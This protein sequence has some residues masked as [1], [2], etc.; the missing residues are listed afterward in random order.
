[1]PDTD[2]LPRVEAV[3]KALSVLEA[4]S[5]TKQELTLTEIAEETGLY[6]SA[7]L[8]LAGSLERYG[9]LKRREDRKYCLGPS[10]WRL[11]SLYRKKFDLGEVIRP[12]LRALVDATNQTASLYVIDRDEMLCLYRENSPDPICHYLDEGARFP[13]QFG[14]PGHVLS[15]FGNRDPMAAKRVDAKGISVS[16]GEKNAQLGA[17]SIALLDRQQKLHGAL[18]V[19]GPVFSFDEAERTRAADLLIETAKRLSWLLSG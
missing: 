6:K 5:V 8:R 9:Y 12:A 11:G 15:L 3:E 16:V 18:T 4:F 2:D 1:M 13:L 19:S 14:A 10:L 7:V 17:V